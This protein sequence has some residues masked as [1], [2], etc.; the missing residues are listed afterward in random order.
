M[1]LNSKEI[2]E[3]LEKYSLG[4][5]KSKKLIYTSWNIVYKIQ[6]EKGIYAL[7][8]IENKNKKFLFKELKILNSIDSNI[9]INK[10][11]KNL[12]EKEYLIFNSNYI[13]ISKFLS[14]KNIKKSDELSLKQINQLGYYL[15]LIHKTK[16]IKGIPKTNLYSKMKS[17]FNKINK[18]SQEYIL[19]Q[20]VIHLLE[21]YNF[22]KF[23][24]RESLIHVDLH[25][26][27]FFIE[28]NQ[29]STIM[30]FEEA[31]INPSIYDLGIT[32]L[33]VCWENEELS[34]KRIKE[35]IKGY[36]EN[37]KLSNLE[38]DNILLSM[39]FGGLHTL[40]FLVIGCGINSDFSM[41]YYSIKR[42]NKLIQIVES[43]N[44]PFFSEI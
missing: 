43:N 31:Y 37:H 15:A 22:N 28:K 5:L 17:F 20:K 16:K 35:F 33:D 11:I 1:R 13:L 44:A 24:F 19:Y 18:T 42:L 10:P 8:L 30:D 40:H 3:I 21:K 14:G 9:P 25:K 41:N 2:K 26:G 29:I 34:K 7:K 27:N 39:I 12:L 38:K 6:T 4:K 32:M 36:E 23:K